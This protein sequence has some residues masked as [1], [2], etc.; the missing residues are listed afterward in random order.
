M[1][2]QHLVLLVGRVTED[3]AVQQSAVHVPDHGA[4]VARRVL[5]LGLTLA[6][7]ERRDV[8]LEGLV[9]VPAVGLV[10]RVDFAALGHLHVGVGQHELADRAVVGEARHCC[11][12]VPISR[13]SRAAARRGG[14]VEVVGMEETQ[15]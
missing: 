14:A 10:H 7:L 11:S 3:A 2:C 12:E 9:P 4:D 13:L 1:H 5:R 6:S 15:F 8:L